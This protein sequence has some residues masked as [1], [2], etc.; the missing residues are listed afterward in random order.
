MS[1][2]R[3]V[4]K[5]KLVIGEHHVMVN[6][7]FHGLGKAIKI[8][9]AEKPTTK[10]K[11]FPSLSSDETSS[12]AFL[13]CRSYIQCFSESFQID[14]DDMIQFFTSRDFL[15]TLAIAQVM[16]LYNVSDDAAMRR[17]GG[18]VLACLLLLGTHQHIGQ[19]RQHNHMSSFHISVYYHLYHYTVS[20]L[21]AIYFHG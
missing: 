17:D 21:N 12:H 13:H 4:L 7:Y 6:F 1:T 11:I 8:K 19:V 3:K 9:E 14:I 15:K 2:E 10:A 18:L 5:R 20:F 16:T